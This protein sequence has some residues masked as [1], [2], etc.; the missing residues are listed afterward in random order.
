MGLL[1]CSVQIFKRGDLD[2]VGHPCHPWEGHTEGVPRAR[3]KMAYC[4]PGK[5]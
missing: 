1:T 4:S 3:E 5:N 2:Q